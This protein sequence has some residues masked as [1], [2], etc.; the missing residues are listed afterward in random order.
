[1]FTLGTAFAQLAVPALTGHVVDTTQTLSTLQRNQLEAK[2]TEFERV[3]GSQ[4]VVLL[5]PSTQPEDITSYANRVGNE[6]KI[7]R[8]EVGDGVLLVVALTD[9]RVR[10]EVA[11]T[12]EGA[13]PD[14]AAKRVIE[15]AITPRF[16]QGDYAGG[17]DAAVVQIMALVSGEALP[18]PSQSAQRGR[19]PGDGFNWMDL[20]IFLFIAVPVVGA[21]AKSILGSRLGSVATGVVAGGIAMW[22]TAS[23][24]IAGLAGVAAMVFALLSRATVGGRGGLGG[25]GFGGGGFSGGSSGGG[26]GGFRSGGGGDFGGGGAS[27]GW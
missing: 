15:Q 1:M 3:H 5:V 16:K 21:V 22:I 11:K 17:L 19:S 14:L 13:I 23:L 25:G 9:H 7:G 20:G 8:K 26:G 27:G 4:V 10:I 2:L 18:A 24:L 12:L 6:W